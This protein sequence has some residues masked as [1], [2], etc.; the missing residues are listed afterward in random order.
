ML[1][2][3][4]L[5]EGETRA[6]LDT[7]TSYKEFNAQEKVD[8]VRQVYDTLDIQDIAKEH[9][10]HYRD[11]ALALFAQISVSEERKSNLLTL[12]DQLMAREH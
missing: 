2:A 10:N 8:T 11:K 9:M 5:A 6:S 4:E 7:W 3:F 12:T 1:K